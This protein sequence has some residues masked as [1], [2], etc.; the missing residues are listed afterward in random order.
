M[1]WCD[2]VPLRSRYLDR[3]YLLRAPRGHLNPRAHS[4][5]S[6]VDSHTRTCQILRYRTGAE[7]PT[8]VVLPSL[9]VTRESTN[10]VRG[11]RYDLTTAST[12]GRILQL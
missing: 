1:R 10:P 4:Y 12:V 6:T 3:G 7:S 11:W 8:T 2:V 9:P 5:V